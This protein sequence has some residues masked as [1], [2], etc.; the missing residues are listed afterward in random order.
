MPEEDY[1]EKDLER[2]NSKCYNKYYEHLTN[3]F[4]I[5]LRNSTFWQ[6]FAD[7]TLNK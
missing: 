5:T 4:K 3:Q 1:T 6:F 2:I 7:K